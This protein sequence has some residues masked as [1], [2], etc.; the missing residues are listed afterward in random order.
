MY[1]RE[2]AK[3]EAAWRLR[4]KKIEDKVEQMF[5]DR[6]ASLSFYAKVHVDAAWKEDCVDI[7]CREVSRSVD[8]ACREVRV[9]LKPHLR[10]AAKKLNMHVGCPKRRGR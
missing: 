9:L 4:S 5:R 6:V 7:A 3:K 2:I 10:L 1:K 8:I